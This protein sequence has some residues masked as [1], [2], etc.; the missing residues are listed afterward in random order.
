VAALPRTLDLF[1]PAN[2]LWSGNTD[3]S[4]SAEATG[5]WL[6]ANRVEPVP[7]F[8][9]AELS[10]GDGATLNVL[11]VNVKGSV[12][13]VEW[14]GF[15]AL[16]PLG[17]NFDVLSE[18]KNGKAV[19]PVTALLLADAGYG[20]SNPP[21]WIHN[22]HPQVAV[23]SVAAGDESGLPDASVLD[24]LSGTTLLRT[25]LN[26]WIEISSDGKGFWVDVE[27]KSNEN[28]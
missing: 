6:A 3:A 8:A 7:A 16:L 5:R 26:G 22:V 24:S 11:E 17:M 10:L 2:V 20:P 4:F 23:L 27:K 13:L 25:D 18:L 28:E 21:E 15:R 14:E 9:G 12:I 19:G 1:P